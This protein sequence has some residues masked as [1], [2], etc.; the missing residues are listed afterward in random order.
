LNIYNDFLIQ[1]QES[2]RGGSFQLNSLFTRLIQ[3]AD[4]EPDKREPFNGALAVNIHEYI[5]YLHN[6]TTPCGIIMFSNAINF[7]YEFLHGTDKEGSYQAPPEK[8]ENAEAFLQVYRIVLG[9]ATGNL[10]PKDQHIWGWNFGI[11]KISPQPLNIHGF[12]FHNFESVSIDTKAKSFNKTYEFSLEI[13]HHFITEGVAYEVEREIRK[14]QVS[15]EGVDEG[16]PAYPYLAYEHLI[17]YL[18]GRK[19][20]WQERIILGTTALMHICPGRGLIDSCK[21]L[22]QSKSTD[23][24]EFL[25]YYR[26]LALEFSNFSNNFKSNLM[27][28]M[29][30]NIKGSDQLERGLIQYLKIISAALDARKR[31]PFMET[32]LSK[33]NNT[34]EFHHHI[35]KLAPFWTY[36]Q[37]RQSEGV[38]SWKGNAFIVNY[39][40][41]PAISTLQSIF[42]Y[43]QIHIKSDG[44]IFNT[45]E[46]PNVCCPFA[47]ACEIEKSHGHPSEC[48]SAP[49]NFVTNEKINGTQAV[50]FYTSG[51]KSLHYEQKKNMSTALKTSS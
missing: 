28:R 25:K 38:I 22:K 10:P 36:Q 30:K 41:E 50:C 40:D 34:N 39:I 14:R 16:T 5:H 37:K 19:S 2:Q 9:Q 6:I 8:N 13:G 4:L 3:D 11:A 15:P 26:S 43:L 17:D 29:I 12:D 45:K 27:P 20:S 48:R 42:N 18:I 47:G 51:V 49:W 21:T 23:A 31:F 35:A 32:L 1:E 7:L 46:L 24:T 44:T 33:I